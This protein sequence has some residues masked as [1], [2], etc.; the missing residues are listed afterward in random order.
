MKD[1]ASVVRIEELHKQKVEAEEDIKRFEAQLQAGVDPDID[2]A[3]PG[4]TLQT[5]TV[6]L[7][8]NA[9][10]KIES[11]ERAL[12]QARTGSYGICESCGQ[13][14]APERLE[15]FPQATLCVSCKSTQEAKNARRYRT[16]YPVAYAA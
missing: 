1:N 15:I 3:D 13:A 6:A 8:R 9:R 4:L 12:A 10:R 5:V 16:A 14:I 11:I 7:L 2:E